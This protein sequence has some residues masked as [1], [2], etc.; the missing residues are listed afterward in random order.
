MLTL[1]NQRGG[2]GTSPSADAVVEAAQIVSAAKL[3]SRIVVRADVL[4]SHKWQ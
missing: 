3:L 4:H 2:I 1:M